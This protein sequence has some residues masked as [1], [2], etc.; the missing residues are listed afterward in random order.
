MQRLILLLVVFAFKKTMA[1]ELFVYTEPASNMAAK[2]FGLRLN[3]YLMNETDTKKTNYHLI[4]EIMWGA[5]KHLMI[6]AEAFL[7]NRNKSFVAE[8]GAIYAKYRFYSLDEVH[9]HFR[10]AAFG[11]VSFNNSDIHQEEINMYGHNTGF[12]AGLVATQL[13]YKVAVSSAISIAKAFDNGNNNKFIYVQLHD[14]C[15]SF[16]CEEKE[17]SSKIYKYFNVEILVFYWCLRTSCLYG[18]YT[19]IQ[20]NIKDKHHCAF[21]WCIFSTSNSSSANFFER[22]S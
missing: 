17:S 22:K 13:L 4:P 1:Q 16:L 11:R 19:G 10:M 9:S 18:Y 8:G 15:Y 21:K 5:S 14:Y 7:S 2:S 6:H 3:N 20:L 12:E